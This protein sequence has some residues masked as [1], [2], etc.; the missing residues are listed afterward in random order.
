MLFPFKL[1]VIFLFIEW[2]KKEQVFAPLQLLEWALSALRVTLLWIY[3]YVSQAGPDAVSCQKSL[4]ESLGK[5]TMSKFAQQ[6]LV[7]VWLITDVAL[8]MR[9]IL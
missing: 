6:S 8:Q 2:Q 7:H 1:V 9:E 4:A 5:A 3:M